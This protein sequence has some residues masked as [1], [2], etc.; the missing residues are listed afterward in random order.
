MK[1]R[2]SLAVLVCTAAL[3]SAVSLKA[4][5]NNTKR[6]LLFYPST[7]AGNQLKSG[8]YLVKYKAEGTNAKVTFLRGKKVIATVE[9]QIVNRHIH[10]SQT[11]VVYETKPDGTRTITEIRFASPDRA[12][13]F[14]E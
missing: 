3:L 13:V 8:S 1:L 11:Q 4:A 12:I 2:K 5:R 6:V 7:V 10:Y 14:E 9:G